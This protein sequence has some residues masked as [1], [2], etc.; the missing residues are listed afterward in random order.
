MRTWIDQ[1]S[2]RTPKKTNFRSESLMEITFVLENTED[3]AFG[4]PERSIFH[5][6]I[7]RPIFA[8]SQKRFSR[9]VEWNTETAS[10]QIR[11]RNRF[12]GFIVPQVDVS[13]G[14]FRQDFWVFVCFPLQL[15]LRAWREIELGTEPKFKQ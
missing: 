1:F 4:N 11:K 9:I 10:I 7:E 12:I 14:I 8:L 2:S 15:C 5:S 3:F 6:R 13:G